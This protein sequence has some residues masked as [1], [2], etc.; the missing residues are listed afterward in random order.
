MPEDTKRAE[1][2]QQ[3]E[4]KEKEKTFG[5]KVPLAKYEA[6][7]AEL[8]KAE[9][10]AANWKNE[11]YRAYADMQNLRKS[12]EDEKRDALRYRA[13]G[14]LENLLPALDGFHMALS[15]EVNDPALKNYLMGFTYIYNNIKRTLEEEGVTEIEPQVGSDYDMNTMHA[16]E[17]VESD[18]E[19]NKIVKVLAKGYKLHDRLI[20]PVMVSVS[21]TK[22]EKE[23]DKEETNKP[24]VE[25]DEAHKA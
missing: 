5:K 25:V 8:E 14:F 19:P 3:E 12:L 1:E 20:R 22:E 10:D 23:A 6:L 24:A 17:A 11:Y 15:G 4:V 9:L 16:V 13:A 7:Q 2:A 21:K 18:L